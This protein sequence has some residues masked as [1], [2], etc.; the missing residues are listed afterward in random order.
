VIVGALVGSADH[1]DRHVAVLEYLLVADR[2]LEQVL[3]LVDPALE[4]EGVQS[5]G[6]HGHL[7]RSLF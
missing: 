3:M 1:L 4:I 7:L 6:C 2:R 5:S